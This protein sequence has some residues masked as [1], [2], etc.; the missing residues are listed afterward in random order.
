[1]DS[2]NLSVAAGAGAALYILYKIFLHNKAHGQAS[3]GDADQSQRST[4]SSSGGGP[5]A[6]ETQRVRKMRL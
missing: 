6:Y 4:T 2:K 5:S 3:S 1:M